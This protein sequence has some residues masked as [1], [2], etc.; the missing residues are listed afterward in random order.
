MLCTLMTPSAGRARVAGHDVAAAPAA[1]RRHIG[2]VFQDT[3][4]DQGLTAWENLRFHAR[5]HGVPAGDAR[6]ARAT[7]WSWPA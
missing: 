1:V 6:R 2:L 4:L 7:C 5:L 3:T